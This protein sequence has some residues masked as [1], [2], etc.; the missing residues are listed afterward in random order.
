MGY[1]FIEKPLHTQ[2]NNGIRTRDS[3]VRAVEFVG[4]FTSVTE[5]LFG[6]EAKATTT[7]EV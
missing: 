7:Q 6:F 5:F 2:N 3:C 4:H 1:R